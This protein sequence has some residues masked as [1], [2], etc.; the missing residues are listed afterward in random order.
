[1]NSGYRPLLRRCRIILSLA[2]AAA[3]GGRVAEGEA[4]IYPEHGIRLESDT[5]IRPLRGGAPRLGSGEG[6][7][8]WRRN[9]APMVG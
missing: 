6:L 9:R 7:Q 8:A 1:M 4:G 2:E 3:C 5:D